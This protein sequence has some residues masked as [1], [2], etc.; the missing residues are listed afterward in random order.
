M[1]TIKYITVLLN[2]RRIKEAKNPANNR[3]IA[4]G[5]KKNKAEAAQQYLKCF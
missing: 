1:I 2:S 4:S 3:K 5:L